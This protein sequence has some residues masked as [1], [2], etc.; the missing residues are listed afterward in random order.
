MVVLPVEVHVVPVYEP[1]RLRGDQLVLAADRRAGLRTLVGD[2]PVVVG[3]QEELVHV[4][5]ISDLVCADQLHYSRQ[6]DSTGDAE[7]RIQPQRPL[8][9]RRLL[10]GAAGGSSGGLPRLRSLLGS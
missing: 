1:T 4:R 3:G 2:G 7:H 10:G 8:P 5:R 9:R 6:I